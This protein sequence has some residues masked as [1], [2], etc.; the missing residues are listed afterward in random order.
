[1]I[2]PTSY[3]HRYVDLDGVRVHHLVVPGPGDG[4]TFVLVHGL[5]GSLD[6]WLS[7]IPL[8]TPHGRVIALDLAG[9]GLTD[10]D[11]KDASIQANLDLL[12]RFVATV[13]DGPV[14]IVGNSMGG[15]LTAQLAAKDPRRVAGAVLIDPALPPSPFA[16][17]NPYVVAGFSVYVVPGFDVWAMGKRESRFTA[18][19]LVE[20]TLRL[21]TTHPERI[22]PDVVEAHVALAK[23]RAQEYPEGDV[24]FAVAA[25]TLLRQFARRRQ[26][27]RT[28]SQILPPVLLIHG[29]RDL[30]INVKSARATAARHPG[31]TYVEG[32][33]KGHTP[34][35][36]F[37]EWVAEQI[38]TWAGDRGIT[39]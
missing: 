37:P 6:N 23:R 1:M 22:D 9:F 3:R 16:R 8:L 24:A 7:L 36:D 33:D 28:L 25:R 39:R 38:L 11:P 13:G 29:D 32:A 18:R 2:D 27:G 12:G 35:L 31:W 17:P 14:V 15:M 5:G 4:P 34:F 20:Q 19:Q 10:A 30:L 26:F 21:V